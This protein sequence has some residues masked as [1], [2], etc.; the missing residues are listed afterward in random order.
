MGVA[1]RGEVQGSQPFV[2]EWSQSSLS[3]GLGTRPF[4]VRTI[5]RPIWNIGGTFAAF[6]GASAR[7]DQAMCPG[8][9]ATFYR[10]RFR[11]F[12]RVSRRWSASR[13]GPRASAARI[14]TAI[15]G[16]SC[17]QAADRV[18]ETRPAERGCARPH[19]YERLRSR[20]RDVVRRAEA[21]C[22]PGT[23]LQN[24]PPRTGPSVS[25]ECLRATRQAAG[26]ST[27]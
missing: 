4:S 17:G 21:R 7:R 11:F 27:R 6:A 23:L 9:T 26:E 10:P 24:R 18:M 3:E 16:T 25:N 20:V 2:A 5:L 12:S 13:N 19:D 1:L 15:I 8:P 22:P 14:N